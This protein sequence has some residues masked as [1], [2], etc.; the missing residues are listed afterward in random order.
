VLF[1]D[2]S[3][4]VRTA[5]A[6]VLGAAGHDVVLA[7]DGVEAVAA[8]FDDPPDVVLLDLYMPRLTGWV[9]CRLIKDD[10]VGERTPVLVMTGV[11]GPEDRFWADESGADGFLTKDEIGE[12]LLARIHALSLSRALSELSAD[13]PTDVPHEPDDVLA[14]VCDVLDRKLFEATVVNEIIAIGIRGLDPAEAMAQMLHA[15]RRLVAYDLGAFALTVDRSIAVRI[16][17]RVPGG[18]FDDFVAMALRRLNDLAGTALVREEVGVR[19]IPGGEVDDSVPQISWQSIHV[20]PLVARGRVLGVVC[21]AAAAPGIF[22][23]PSHRT[24]RTAG[25]AM[26]AVIEGC[27]RAPSPT[28]A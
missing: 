6:D 28:G 26:A 2:D 1:A 15:L 27:S 9:A 11:D 4:T 19:V 14:R 10:R 12:P 8:F 21:L 23:G 5:V 20:Q 16:A 25:P 7:T 3:A 18:A 22:E 13:E 17:R 24:L